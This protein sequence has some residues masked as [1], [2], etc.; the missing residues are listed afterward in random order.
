MWKQRWRLVCTMGYSHEQ[1]KQWFLE[2]TA[3][4]VVVANRR[5]SYRLS[6]LGAA[7]QG[8]VSLKRECLRLSGSEF[9]VVVSSAAEVAWGR[10]RLRFWWTQNENTILYDYVEDEDMFEACYRAAQLALQKSLT[11]LPFPTVLVNVVLEFMLGVIP[12]T[13]EPGETPCLW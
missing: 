5:N 1:L 4:W 9:E 7:V 2:G 10:K 3:K 13:F 12:R 8:T 6:R 11:G